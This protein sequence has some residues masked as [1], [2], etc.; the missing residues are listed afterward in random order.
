MVRSLLSSL[1]FILGG[2]GSDIT[3]SDGVSTTI[4]GPSDSVATIM[5][6]DSVEVNFRGEPTSF[7]SLDEIDDRRDLPRFFL[8]RGNFDEPSGG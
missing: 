8:E 4:G 3:D 7:C 1:F 5:D 2:S 6:E